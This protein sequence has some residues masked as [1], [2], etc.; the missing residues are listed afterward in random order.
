MQNITSRFFNVHIFNSNEIRSP[1]CKCCYS[2]QFCIENVTMTKQLKQSMFSESSK[3]LFRVTWLL[4]LDETSLHLSKWHQSNWQKVEVKSFSTVQWS[5]SRKPVI[6]SIYRH[7]TRIRW[8]PMFNRKHSKDS[9][10][11]RTIIT[12]VIDSNA[13][14]MPCCR[15]WISRQKTVTSSSINCEFQPE[16]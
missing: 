13:I 5:S 7:W 3:H 10:A 4:H 6:C 1:I 14:L 15:A 11:S 16:F 2:I 8:S 12:R 9:C